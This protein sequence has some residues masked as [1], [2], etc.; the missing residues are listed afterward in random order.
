ML[1][2]PEMPTGTPAVMTTRSP[3]RMRPAFSADWH[4]QLHQL[5]GVLG[6]GHGDGLH[7]P[8]KGH[9][10]LHLLLQQQGYHRGL[11]T[12]GADHLGGDTRL[13]HRQD[14]V[15]TDILAVVQAAWAVAAAM[16]RRLPSAALRIRLA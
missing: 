10:A 11:R 6:T 16:E 9:L 4:R 13:T 5:V 1:V 15:G 3:W 7:A 8:V 14:G 2:V 12:E